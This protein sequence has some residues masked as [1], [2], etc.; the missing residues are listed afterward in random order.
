MSSDIQVFVKWKDQTIFAG[1]DV[2]C[3]ITFKNVADGAAE[4]KNGGQHTHQRKQSRAANVT[5]HSDS[6][7]SLKSPHN[8]FFNNH[9]RSFPTRNPQHRISSSLSSP[10]IGSHSFPPP[11]TPRSASSYGHK[12]KRSVSIL[13]IDSEGGGDKTPRTSSQFSR[14][15]QTRG[16]HGRSASLQVV[17]K[18]YEGYEDS[19]QKGTGLAPVVDQGMPF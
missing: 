17:P 12:H 16:G 19:P 5:P 9:R 14:P 11:S 7:F 8:L 18:R 10:L 1:E 6:F 15:W 4:S 2:E 3:T 13:S